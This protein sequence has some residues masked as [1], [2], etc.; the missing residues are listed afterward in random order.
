MS[1]RLKARK[2]TRAPVRTQ[3]NTLR[4]LLVEA[5][6]TEWGRRYNFASIA[7]EGDVVSAFQDRVPLHS[8]EDYAADTQRVRNGEADVFWPGKMKYFAVSSGTASAGKVLPLSDEMVRRNRSYCLDFFFQYLKTSRKYRLLLGRQFTMPGRIEPD[9]NYPGTLV[10]EVSGFLLVGVPKF[11]KTFYRDMPRSAAFL[12]NWQEKL[13]AAVDYA[14]NHDIRVV[15]TVPSWALSLFKKAIVVYNERNGTNVR[16]VGEIW[17]NLGVYMSGG[18]ALSSYR[19]VLEDLIGL[20]GVDFIEGYG[21]SEGFLSYQVDL[22]DPSMLLLLDN[23]IFFEFIRFD[24]LHLPE[25]RRYSV[26]DVEVGVP[27]APFISTCSGLWSFSVGDVLRFTSTNPH[28]ILVVGRTSDVLDRYGE[29]VFGED[30]GMALNLACEK[31]GSHIANYHLTT[32][33]PTSTSMPHIEW[34]IEFA[35]PPLSVE[36]FTQAID[37]ALCSINRHYEIRR[38]SAS[39]ASPRI[40]TLRPGTFSDWLSANRRYVSTQSKVLR[41]SEDSENANALIALQ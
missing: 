3:A 41:M 22:D 35:T 13:S 12:P 37:Q 29:K 17:P 9:R 5:S 8:Y 34:L 15:S 23:G 4:R 24:E 28:K 26:R 7:R 38:A 19:A 10:G 31:T 2:F 30:A 14:L 39:F 18:V 27:Y 40:V 11:I 20:P 6:D 32:R 16:S 1:L 33:P 25:P 21:A 36:S